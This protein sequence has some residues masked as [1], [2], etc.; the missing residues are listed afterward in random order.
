MAVPPTLGLNSFGRRIS[1][2]PLARTYANPTESTHILVVQLLL[3]L[4]PSPNF[5]L[6][7]YLLAFFIPATALAL[8]LL[9]TLALARS[10]T[11]APT[12]HT[13]LSSATTLALEP[14][15][16]CSQQTHRPQP[17]DAPKPSFYTSRTIYI[18]SY[19]LI[20]FFRTPLYNTDFNRGGMNMQC[21]IFC[22]IYI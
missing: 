6:L 7:I 3:Q 22:F 1:H 4:L 11:I 2:I 16:L 8:E 5:S 14:S 12:T 19:T 17:I 9:Q 20:I 21:V 10:L 13:G 15:H 18:D